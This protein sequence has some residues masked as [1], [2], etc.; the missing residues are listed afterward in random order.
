[1]PVQGACRRNET[2][3]VCLFM[4][5][6]VTCAREQCGGVPAGTTSRHDHGSTEHSARDQRVERILRV[7][8]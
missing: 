4:L 2:V 1:M 5:V 3:E 6:R 7:V 8:K